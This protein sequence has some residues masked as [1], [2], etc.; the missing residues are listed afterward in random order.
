[1]K[2][3]LLCILLLLLPCCALADLEAH[4]IDV[5]Y[6]EC[7]VLICDGEA[8]IID[9]GPV[10]AN[11]LVFTYIRR[12]GVT[13]LKYAVATHTNAEHVGGLPAAFHAADVQALYVP[14][15]DAS[16]ERFQE[17]LDKAEEKSAKIVVPSA[18][19]V[20][21]L[22]GAKITVLALT[23][24]YDDPTSRVMILRVTYGG[25]AFLLCS[26][27]GGQAAA[28]MLKGEAA[29]AADV[30]RISCCGSDAAEATLLDAVRA[31]HAVI[32]CTER[33][34]HP[35]KVVM[36]RLLKF[37]TI[38]LCTDVVGDVIFRSD[39]IT[40]TLVTESHYV[41][42]QNSDI[43]HRHT[44]SSVKKMKESNKRMLYSCEEAEYKGYRGCKNCS[45]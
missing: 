43:F 13:G 19:D 22:G 35:D 14:G 9:G 29:L 34:T 27:A 2:R 23:P 37:N 4:F 7:T 11:D 44:C 31:E 30:L 36:E 45:P 6:G 15:T 41:G 39:G 26:T 24:A 1:M 18:G 17:L 42:N 5:R 32:S 3:L 20:L 21:T 25:H 12:L 33:Y 8:M 10:S 38:P 28:T 40:M 16:G